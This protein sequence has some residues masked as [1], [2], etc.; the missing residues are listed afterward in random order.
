MSQRVLGDQFTATTSR[1]TPKISS[2]EG[3]P[4]R[5]PSVERVLRNAELGYDGVYKPIQK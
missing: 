1:P 2:S 5:N 3:K 4:W